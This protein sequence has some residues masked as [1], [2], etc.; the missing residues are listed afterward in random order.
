MDEIRPRRSARAWLSISTLLGLTSIVALGLLGPGCREES[1]LPVDRNLPPE[2]F[3]TGAPGDSQTS[4]Y[5][6]RL[7]WSGIDQD[8]EVI[9]YEFAVTESLPDLEEIEYQFTERTDSLFRF[10]VEPTREILG[11]R[12]YVRAID[13]DGRRDPVPAWTFFG[14]RNTC[15]PEIL[16][17][18]AIGFSPDLA[19][20][21]EI[22]SNATRE[23][24]VSD[25]IPAGWSVCFRWEGQDCDVVIEPDG[26]LRQ[27]GSIQRYFRNLAPREFSELGGTLADTSVCYTGDQL[28]SGTYFLRVRGVDDAGFS[29]ADP[30]VRSFVANLD[31]ITRFERAYDPVLQDSFEVIYADTVG[32]LAPEAYV[33]IRDGDTLSLPVSGV[34]IRTRLTG[35]DPDDP[36]GLGSIVL[37]QARIA[38][39]SLRYTDLF[40]E[41][42]VYPLPGQSLSLFTGSG[43]WTIQG[44]SE[45]RLGRRDGTPAEFRIH[46]NRPARWKTRG[47]YFGQDFEQSPLPG[48]TIEVPAGSMTLPVAFFALDPDALNDN[49]NFMEYQYRFESYPGGTT[50]ESF[51]PFIPAAPLNQGFSRVNL[52]LQNGQPFRE[53]NYTLTV[54]AQEFRQENLAQLGKRRISRT[55]S[56]RVVER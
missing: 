47:V 16:F 56:F 44:R 12:F 10:Q 4:F 54:R 7:H 6:V 39:I 52:T 23:R 33:P 30:A 27:V 51:G 40:L 1:V 18:Q 25:T 21:L 14:A 19:E 13:D 48:G 5:A 24:D 43:V 53:G 38:E 2:T 45:D 37:Y 31:P 3:L 35:Y 55:V 32:N 15:A 29:G 46:V 17:T 20:T 28:P 34:R 8:G 41:D 50:S 9:G 22:T 42:P 11:H 49:V 26:T 36:E